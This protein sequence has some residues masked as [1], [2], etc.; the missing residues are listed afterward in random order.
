MH[1]SNVAVFRWV[2]LKLVGILWSAF[3]GQIRKKK[4]RS[5]AFF[6]TSINTL[7]ERFSVESRFRDSRLR[8]PVL[9]MSAE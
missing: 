5:G 9:F 2:F 7:A 4:F 8:V 1:P 6:Q 3:T